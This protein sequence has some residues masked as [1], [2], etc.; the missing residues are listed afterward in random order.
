MRYS[1]TCHIH[2]VREFL[3]SSHLFKIMKSYVHKTEEHY[4]VLHQFS[5]V[6]Q[7]FEIFLKNLVAWEI[8]GQ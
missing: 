6:F 1:R 2:F 8:Y 4:K 5:H 3:C 7:K